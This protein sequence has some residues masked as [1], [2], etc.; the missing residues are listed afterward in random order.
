MRV[1]KWSAGGRMELGS[2]TRTK[3]K[4]GRIKVVTKENNDVVFT[5]NIRGLGK[6][7]LKSC[8]QSKSSNEGVELV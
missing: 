4:I 1:C 8:H 6:G 5:R 2:I 3:E 7:T